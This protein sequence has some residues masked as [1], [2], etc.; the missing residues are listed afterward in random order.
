[1]YCIAFLHS[2][3]L[4]RHT[5]YLHLNSETVL[6]CTF[7]FNTSETFLITHLAC[8]KPNYFKKFLNATVCHQPTVRE[9]LFELGEPYCPIGRRPT[10]PAGGLLEE[11]L[12]TTLSHS[13][14]PFP[15]QRPPIIFRIYSF[16]FPP[17]P[18][19]SMSSLSI[20]FPRQNTVHINL[21]SPT[22]HMH[23]PSHVPS[24]ELHYSRPP[25]PPR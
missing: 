9:P 5:R 4:S 1:M 7:H 21:L 23:S 8:L 18:W 11:P 13:E 6:W 19:S 22:C 10:I 14:R 20:T 24:S 17:T 3:P 12:Q 25:P 15:G 16:M 2:R